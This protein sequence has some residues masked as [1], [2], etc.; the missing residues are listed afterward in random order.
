MTSEVPVFAPAS[1]DLI[2]PF[3]S[4]RWPETADPSAL[5]VRTP[6]KSVSAANEAFH[7]SRHSKSSTPTQSTPGVRQESCLTGDFDELVM[8]PETKSVAYR[9][10]IRTA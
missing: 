3:T 2:R 7:R 10:D 6:M 1:A 5:K 9:W 8:R 4:S